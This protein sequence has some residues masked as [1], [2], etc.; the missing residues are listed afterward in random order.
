[1]QQILL[2]GAEIMVWRVIIKGMTSNMWKEKS[3]LRKIL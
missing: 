3:F 2:I 1:M